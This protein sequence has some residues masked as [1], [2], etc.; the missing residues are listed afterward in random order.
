MDEKKYSVA[1]KHI[2]PDHVILDP[3]LTLT[4]PKYQTACTGMDA[5]CQGIESYWSVN[6]TDESKR[7][8]R[9]AIELT[10][11]NIEKAV[12]NPKDKEVRKK[13]LEGANYSGKAINI[14][15]T[16]GAHACSYIITSKC[17]IPHGHAVA[18][19]MKEFLKYN[20]TNMDNLIDYRGIKYFK[21]T[22]E[23]LYSILGSSSSEQA[24]NKF[25]KK[26]TQL[27]LKTSLNEVCGEIQ[28]K[29]LI[30]GVNIE[31]LKN[32]PIQVNKKE[33]KS[34]FSSV[35]NQL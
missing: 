13:M 19:M 31:R 23:K 24:L 4:L 14:S 15:K 29:E 6:S 17:G 9:K 18:I 21:N 1:H 16:T 35:K 30:D 33:L 2:I 11:K 22:I 3:E 25:E 32:N 26:M 12:K 34:I 20:G 8:A 10:W 5:L 28:I 7:Y 27:E